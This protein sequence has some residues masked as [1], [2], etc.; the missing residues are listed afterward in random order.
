MRTI[1]KHLINLFVSR[2]P[3]KN[4]ADLIKNERQSVIYI[5][6]DNYPS[7]TNISRLPQPIL[8]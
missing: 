1:E 5:S 3:E 7:S 6:Q 4:R 2:W 8:S